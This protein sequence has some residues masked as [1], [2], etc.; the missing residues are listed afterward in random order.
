MSIDSN[1]QP[2][3]NTQYECPFCDQTFSEGRRLT[4]HAKRMHDKSG[5]DIYDLKYPNVKKVCECGVALKF[6]DQDRGYQQS[7]GSCSRKA[8]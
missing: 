7:C 5:K 4:L 3:Q 1:T 2:A 6:I 8:K